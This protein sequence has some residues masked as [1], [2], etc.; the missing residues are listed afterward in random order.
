MTRPDRLSTALLAVAT[1]AL[2]CTGEVADGPGGANPGQPPDKGKPPID[3]PPPSTPVTPN[4]SAGPTPLRRLTIFEYNNT[5]RDL[6]GTAAKAIEGGGVAVDLPSDVGFVNG[7][8]ITSSVDARQFLDVTEKLTGNQ[9]FAALLPQG[10]GAPAAGAE[11]GCAKDFIKKFGLRAYRRPLTGDEEGDLFTLYSK[12]RGAEVG[13]NFQDGIKALITGMIQ[14]AYFLYRW[15]LGGDPIKEGALVRLNSYE[16]A[17][18]LSYFLTATMP[19]D[20]L[21]EAAG[22]NE[23]VSADKLQEHARRLISG[24]KAKDGLR[25]FVLQWLGVTALPNQQK[26]PMYTAYTPEVGKA[27]L[28]ETAEFFANLVQSPQGAKL[29]KLFTS[30]SSFVNGPLAKLYGNNGVTGDNLREVQLDEAQRGG[31]LTE[32][33]FLAAHA[34]GDSGHP[35]KRG[36]RVLRN[37]V[38][39]NIEPP[40]NVDIPPV[41]DRKPGQTTRARF[42]EATKGGAICE[43]CHTTINPVGFAFEQYDAVGQFRTM[44]DGKPVDASGTLRLGSGEINFKNALELS[45]GLAVA[46]ETRECMTRQFLRYVLRRPDLPEEAGSMSALT[47]AFQKS[48][49][50]LKEL[51]VATTKVHAFT[52]RQPLPGEGQK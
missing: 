48:G 29:E 8:P 44:E 4:D 34:E 5:I 27:M 47:E 42:E 52:H 21:F 22:R 31:I 28:D 32:G 26:D 20:Q 25:D 35:V 11:E 19:D 38:C 51:L 33:S 16:L 41:G 15:E 18:R 7:A 24:P 13:G 10:C 46:P 30:R 9:A 43:G 45:R 36:I 14:S 3:T 1:F 49:F 39:L 6:L 40:M 12:I 37:V 17:S 23:L 2:G 50:D